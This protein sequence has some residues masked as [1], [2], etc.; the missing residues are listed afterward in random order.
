MAEQNKQQKQWAKIVTKAWTDE[1]VNVP[2]RVELKCV[3]ATEKQTWLVLPPK[4]TAGEIEEGEE[5]LAAN[6]LADALLAAIGGMNE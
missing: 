4:P 5:R 1:G 6:G 3:E 2:E